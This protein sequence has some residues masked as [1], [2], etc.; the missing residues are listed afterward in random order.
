MALFI[1][2]TLFLIMMVIS[3]IACQIT[4]G[5]KQERRGE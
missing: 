5:R 1:A 4:C 2:I 3:F